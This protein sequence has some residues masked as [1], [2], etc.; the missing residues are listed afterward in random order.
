M[1]YVII[2][3][4]VLVIIFTIA[5]ISIVRQSETVIVERLGKY[6]KTLSA[7]INIIIPIIDQRRSVVWRYVKEGYDGSTIVVRRE[8]SKI[9]LR[10]VGQIQRGIGAR[11]K[12]AN[13]Y[14]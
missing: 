2:A 12:R 6:C 9:D 14:L 1:I 4:A 5:G 7:G 3:I 13:C 8:T 10:S 11:Q